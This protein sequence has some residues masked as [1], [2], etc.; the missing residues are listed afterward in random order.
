MHA[1]AFIELFE[2]ATN[3]PRSKIER[4]TAS[5]RTD[6]RRDGQPGGRLTGGSEVALEEGNWLAG[7][8]PGLILVARPP[9]ATRG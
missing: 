5:V 7:R 1:E 6:G 4:A 9:G 8:K 3:G 2:R